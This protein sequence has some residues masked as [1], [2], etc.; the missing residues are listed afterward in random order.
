MTNAAAVSNCAVV[1]QPERSASMSRGRDRTCL[2]VCGDLHNLGDLALL[3]QNIDRAKGRRVLARQW[4]A[5]PDTVLQ[6]VER[7]GGSVLDGRRL[8]SCLSEALHCD[9]VI[10]GEAGKEGSDLRLAYLVGVAFAVE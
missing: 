2:V 3:L 4:S 10:G 7:A 6:Q 9:M 1:A 8:L 5:L